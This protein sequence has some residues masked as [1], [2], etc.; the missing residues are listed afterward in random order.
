MLRPDIDPCRGSSSLSDFYRRL[1]LPSLTTPNPAVESLASRLA[2]ARPL[3]SGVQSEHQTLVVRL[4]LRR[5]VHC[6]V[7]SKPISL[8][9]PLSPRPAV[10]SNGALRC[11]SSIKN[12]TTVSRKDGPASTRRSAAISIHRA[13]FISSTRFSSIYAPHRSSASTALRVYYSCW[14]A[15]LVITAFSPRTLHRERDFGQSVIDKARK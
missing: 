14:A 6:P 4:W 3:K 12:T 7:R 2:S 9:C 11:Y 5:A 8:T 10:R 15:A 1:P 13:V